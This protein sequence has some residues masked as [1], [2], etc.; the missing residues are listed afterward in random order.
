MNKNL[1][2]VILEQSYVL[3]KKLNELCN[4]PFPSTNIREFIT[5]LCIINNKFIDLF[6]GQTNISQDLL[7]LY[8]EA[9]IS[10]YR[11]VMRASYTD[12]HTHPI[13]VMIPVKEIVSQIAHDADFFTCP[14]SDINYFVS[15][16]WTSFNNTMKSLKIHDGTQKQ[17]IV[18]G[19]PDL[20]KDNILLGCVMG[21]ELGHFID[22]F[23][24][25]GITDRLLIEILK[26]KNMDSLKNYLSFDEST[27]PPDQIDN[28]KALATR[29]LFSLKGLPLYNWLRELV[30]D[31]CGILLYGLASHLASEY[32]FMLFSISD[33]THLKDQ[34]TDSHPRK[35]L[36]S[37]IKRFALEKYGFTD[38]ISEEIKTE[39]G[40]WHSN[41]ETAAQ[42]SFDKSIT[43][44][45]FGGI[46]FSFQFNNNSLKLIEEMLEENLNLI[47]EEVAK[48]PNT[49]HYD[50]A[51]FNTVVPKLCDKLYNFIPPN[52]VDGAPADSISI[53]NAAWI[54]YITW[55]QNAPERYRDFKELELREIIN[56]L[57]RKGISAA[58]I[59][60]RWKNVS[61]I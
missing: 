52:E 6:T 39:I 7:K 23:Y 20:H 58:S 9:F 25:L 30:A 12:T 53:L 54:S 32:V 13:E 5:E 49:I 14:I 15:E 4:G 2:N 17:R 16:A 42:E 35:I 28:I 57:T 26:H 48:I 36:R 21:H 55:K 46:N 22:I 51:I 18:L 47:V 61:I 38:V 10:F 43:I 19:F 8:N 44:P 40:K 37:K 56:N 31:A 59:H 11:L 60:R 24:N 27:I 33:K 41:W 1:L 3:N 34:Y 45:L 29:M 50:S